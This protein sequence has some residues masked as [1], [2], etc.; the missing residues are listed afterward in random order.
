M[1]SLS[2][3][4]AGTP[5]G[6]TATRLNIGLSHVQLSLSFVLEMGGYEMFYRLSVG[7]SSVGTTTSTLLNITS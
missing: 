4:V 5:T 3:T 2:V 6:L 1:T 7:S